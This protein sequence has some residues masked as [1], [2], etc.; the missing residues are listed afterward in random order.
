MVVN[1]Y[2]FEQTVAQD[3]TSASRTR[4]K[5]SISAG[6]RWCARRPRTTRTSRSWSTPPTM[7]R[8]IAG[9]RR[10]R[11]R[12]D[13]RDPLAADAQGVRARGRLR[14]RD[15][16][17]PRRGAASERRRSAP[18]SASRW[19]ARRSLA[20]RRKPPSDGCALRRLSQDR[21]AAPRPRAFVQQRFRY[22]FGD[23]PD[24]RIR[25]LS[26]RRWWRFSSTTRPAASASAATL[27]DAWDKA[28]AT[29]PDSP[30]GGIIITNRPW[31]LEFA[32]AVDEL[33]TEVLIGPDFPPE[34]ASNFCARRKIG[35]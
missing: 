30:F 11:R 19:T 1:F 16:E 34:R 18:A 31:D 6:P 24:S 12:S 21:R 7:R 25:R 20:L 9:A 13:A 4:L 22:Q 35:A 33:F 28:F 17:L 26:R 29:D 8:L 14:L 32:R 27:K 2:P 3:R 10:Q 15:R 23:Q 5:I